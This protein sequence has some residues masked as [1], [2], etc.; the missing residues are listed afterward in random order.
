MIMELPNTV[1][2]FIFFMASGKFFI[3]KPWAPMRASGFEVMS[4]LVLNTLMTTR[5]NGAMKQKKRISRTIHMIAWEIFFWRAAFSFSV[6]T[7]PP[8]LSYRS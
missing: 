3:V 1:Q 8:L 2:K 7:L 6:I 5:T 4:A